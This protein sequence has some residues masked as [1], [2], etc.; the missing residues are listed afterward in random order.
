MNLAEL[1]RA[2]RGVRSG[3]GCLCTPEAWE[4]KRQLQGLWITGAGRAG[5]EGLP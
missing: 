4:G 2:I 5:L 3:L 1:E